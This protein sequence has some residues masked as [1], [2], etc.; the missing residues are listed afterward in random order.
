[1][2]YDRINIMYVEQFY[3][4][5]SFLSTTKH[6]LQINGGNFIKQC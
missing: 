2:G 6:H 1:M 5:I 4:I 3:H